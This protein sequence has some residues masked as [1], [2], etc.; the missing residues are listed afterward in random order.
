M[1]TPWQFNTH[2]PQHAGPQPWG[3]ASA[4]MWKRFSTQLNVQYLQ[5]EGPGAR[6]NS[7]VLS[8][9]ASCGLTQFAPP[10]GAQPHLTVQVLLV[11]FS[12]WVYLHGLYVKAK[13]KF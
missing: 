12:P 2:V 8:I 6:P 3:R 4:S 1:I 10:L 7:V 9:E 13:M 5:Y 11:R